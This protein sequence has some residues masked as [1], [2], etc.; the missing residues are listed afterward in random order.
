M[1]RQQNQEKTAFHLY[2]DGNTVVVSFSEV[3]SADVKG[4]L[5]DILTEAYQEQG[6]ENITV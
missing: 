3:E 6:Q 1:G 4:R 2:I 5:R